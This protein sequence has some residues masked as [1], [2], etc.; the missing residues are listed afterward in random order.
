MLAKLDNR[1][2]ENEVSGVQQPQKHPFADDCLQLIYFNYQGTV[3]LT[4][5]TS[6]VLSGKV[7]ELTTPFGDSCT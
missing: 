4:P 7:E 2:K 5:D 6:A 1:T 3:N